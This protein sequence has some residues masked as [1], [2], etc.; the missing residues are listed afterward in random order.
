[1]RGSVDVIPCRLVGGG[2]GTNSSSATCLSAT[3][4]ASSSSSSRQGC[5]H[6]ES[7]A[8]PT[9]APPTV[10]WRRSRS[11][12]RSGGGRDRNQARQWRWWRWRLPVSVTCA[13]LSVTPREV[14]TAALRVVK[15]TVRSRVTRPTTVGVARGQPTY[16]ENKFYPTFPSFVPSLSWQKRHFEEKMAQQKAFAHLRGQPR[17]RSLA[18]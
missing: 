6:E 5:W 7:S 15:L 1:M 10:N 14:S 16:R 12:A 18:P 9:S 11:G 2:G 17:G 13:C 8:L 4:A 3:T